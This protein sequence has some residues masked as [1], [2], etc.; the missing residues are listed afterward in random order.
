MC[1]PMFLVGLLFDLNY[2]FWRKLS[3]F[4]CLISLQKIL[5]FFDTQCHNFGFAVWHCRKYQIFLIFW[6]LN[7]YVRTT[8]FLI[9]DNLL[10]IYFHRILINS[11]IAE[12]LRYHIFI[13]HI[14][15]SLISVKI[16]LIHSSIFR[17]FEQ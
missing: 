4:N 13:L 3:V 10:S 15:Y 11:F 16:N 6:D 8:F 17:P 12:N 14:E 5:K 1:N 7:V 2:V 9:D